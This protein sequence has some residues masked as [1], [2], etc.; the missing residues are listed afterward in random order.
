MRLCDVIEKSF[1]DLEKLFDSESL[2]N[3]VHGDYGDLG[4]H[5]LF[6]GGWIR[7]NLLREDSDICAVFRKGGVSNRED[8]S[9]LLLEL[10]YIDM[11]V[12]GTDGA[13][14]NTPPHYGKPL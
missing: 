1:S 2:R 14:A 13:N 8:M 10:F 11:R 3:L 4:V 9:L 7:D 6:L 12:R 5:H